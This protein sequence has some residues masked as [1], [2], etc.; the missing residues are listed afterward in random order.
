MFS[1][2]HSSASIFGWLMGFRPFSPR[3]T[4][5]SATGKQI[6]KLI[7]GSHVQERKYPAA[8]LSRLRASQSALQCDICRNPIPNGVLLARYLSTA[9]PD[10]WFPSIS[11][12]DVCLEHRKRLYPC[13]HSAVIRTHWQ[14]C[15]K[16]RRT[17]RHR[18]SVL[19][20]SCEVFDQFLM[21]D[22]IVPIECVGVVLCVERAT[23]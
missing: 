3:H 15:F 17:K 19:V 5:R 23:S 13:G 16:R 9:A 6:V 4:D 1:Y 10:D 21:A 11:N 12:T 2:K 7:V 22:G 20:F 8:K 18:P 14:D